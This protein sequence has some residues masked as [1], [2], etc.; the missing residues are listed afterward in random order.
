MASTDDLF[1][2]LR[3]GDAAERCVAALL[4]PM[5]PMGFA[6]GRLAASRGPTDSEP[7]APP[8]IPADIAASL[9]QDEL[10]VRRALLDATR[11]P[12]PAV[13]AAAQIGL[14][15]LALPPERLEAIRSNLMSGNEILR[16]QAVEEL[17]SMAGPELPAAESSPEQPTADGQ[18]PD[19]VVVHVLPWWLLLGGIALCVTLAWLLR[20]V[21]WTMWIMAGLA[22]LGGLWLAWA[23]SRAVPDSVSQKRL[24][25]RSRIGWSAIIAGICGCAIAALFPIGSVMV[26]NE[27]G[28]TVRLLLDDEPWLTIETGKSK[29]KALPFGTYQLIVRSVQGEQLDQHVISVDE[30]GPYALNVM[31]AQLYFQGTV[32]YGVNVAGGRPAIKMSN[33]KWFLVPKVDYLFRDLPERMVAP[34]PINKTFFS[35]GA[36]PRLQGDQRG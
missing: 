11:D 1:G 12:E 22:V 18:M 13:R 34:H 8:P 7:V 30:H 23:R 10:W 31:G 4:L 28:Q 33:E 21:G 35:K 29:K 17:R 36:P 27:T 20:G 15:S 32:Q 19:I 5:V 2:K 24:R 26:D 14:G 25:A 9:E 6:W 16:Q 3:S